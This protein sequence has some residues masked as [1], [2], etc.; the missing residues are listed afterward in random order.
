MDDDEVMRD[1]FGREITPGCLLVA[2][3][4]TGTK[5]KSGRMRT[6]VAP[7]VVVVD[8]LKYATV[9]GRIVLGQGNREE[10]CRAHMGGVGMIV[11]DGVKPGICDPGAGDVVVDMRYHP[12]GEGREQLVPGIH[13]LGRFNDGTCSASRV[14]TDDEDGVAPYSMRNSV[15][16]YGIGDGGFSPAVRFPAL[17]RQCSVPVAQA[18]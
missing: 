7:S 13:V 8:S 3:D 5:T 6:V 15:I 2:C 16:V 14:C 17:G 12:T 9:N 4:F 11:V 18:G 10:F 1:M